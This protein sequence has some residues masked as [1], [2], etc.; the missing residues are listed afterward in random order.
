MIFAPKMSL[1][2]CTNYQQ[3][4]VESVYTNCNDLVMELNTQTSHTLSTMQ[5]SPEA[6]FLFPYDK[7]CGAKYS[8]R[9]CSFTEMSSKDSNGKEQ[10]F[11]ITKF[12]KVAFEMVTRKQLAGKPHFIDETLE[13]T[14]QELVCDNFYER[15]NAFGNKRDDLFYKTIG[16]DVRKYFQ[17]KFQKYLGENNIR[18]CQ[19]NGTFMDEIKGFFT[20]VVSSNLPKL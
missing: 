5:R 16:R 2:N 10:I 13:E 7:F 3:D 9:K 14:K 20:D 15:K 1:L 11:K 19:K 8:V 17:E 4:M 12:P 18:T 6:E